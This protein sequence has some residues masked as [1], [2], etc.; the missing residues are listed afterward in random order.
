MDSLKNSAKAIAKSASAKTKSTDLTKFIQYTQSALIQTIFLQADTINTQKRWIVIQFSL[1]ALSVIAIVILAT[2]EM[3]K[4]EYFGQTQSGHFTKL[5]PLSITEVNINQI[6][7][8]TEGCVVDALDLNFQN[9]LP[10]INKILNTCFSSKGKQS[11]QDWLLTGSSKEKVSMGKAGSLYADSELGQIV[12]KKITLSS[13][14]RAPG[15]IRSI[16]PIVIEDTGEE[17]ARWEV[18]F[19]L[20]LRKQVGIEGEGTSNLVGQIVV[21]RT[22]SDQ[23]PYGVAIDSFVLAKE[24]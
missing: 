2:R 18:T 24:R 12:A 21:T 19:P 9:P 4:P 10:R 14:L 17:I 23:F 13:S 15:R 1:L 5:S 22:N 8:W 7:I 11:Y 3:P 16:N 20:L 6:R